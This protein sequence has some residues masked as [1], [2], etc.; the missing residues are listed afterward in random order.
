VQTDG[1]TA[2]LTFNLKTY[3]TAED[4]SETLGG[5]WHSTEIYRRSGAD[6]KLISSHWSFTASWLEALVGRV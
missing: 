6:W 5:H 2:V 1:T 4:C 3:G